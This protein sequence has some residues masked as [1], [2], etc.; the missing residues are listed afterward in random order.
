MRKIVVVI[1]LLTA[2]LSVNQTTKA[3]VKVEFGGGLFYGSWL[4][5][6]GINGRIEFDIIENLSMVPMLELSFPKFSTGT[7]LNSFCVMFHYDF[8]V[9]E[10]LEIYP[11]AGTSLKSYLDFDKHGYDSV[12]HRFAF[13]PAFGAGG[14]VKLTEFFSVF[15]EGRIE[16]GS[17]NQFVSSIGVMVWPGQ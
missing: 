5:M 4:H 10:E 17:Y 16:I 6:P 8:E 1:V 7:F 13:N 2:F 12:F 3:Q 9:T 11:I 15:I 14:K